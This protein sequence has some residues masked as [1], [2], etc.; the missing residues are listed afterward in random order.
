MSELQTRGQKSKL[1]YHNASFSTIEHAWKGKHQIKSANAWPK[2]HDF[3]AC[4][5]DHV[6]D[7]ISYFHAK[8]DPIDKRVLTPSMFMYKVSILRDTA[9]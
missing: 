2:F 3:Q 6:Q 8:T 9:E 1:S 4:I 5:G 7:Q